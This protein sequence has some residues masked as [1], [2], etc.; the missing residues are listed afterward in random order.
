MA[1]TLNS[2]CCCV[3]VSQM[4]TVLTPCLVLGTAGVL[5][6][7]WALG[8]AAAASALVLRVVYEAFSCRAG[9][10]KT[11]EHKALLR[12]H[13]STVLMPVAGGHIC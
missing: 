5:Q 9:Q 2:A 12:K 6:R 8:A 1:G 10:Q 4:N 11:E 7:T 13:I 3:A